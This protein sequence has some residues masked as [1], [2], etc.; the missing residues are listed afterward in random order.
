M[1]RSFSYLASFSFFTVLFVEDQADNSTL[2]VSSN[3]TLFEAEEGAKHKAFLL[4]M[5]KRLMKKLIRYFGVKN[6]E[7]IQKEKHMLILATAVHG[8]LEQQQCQQGMGMWK[9]GR[10]YHYGRRRNH[11]N[12]I[13]FIGTRLTSDIFYEF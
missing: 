8:E 7:E 5:S 11:R 9:G 4:R 10:L 1:N 13:F 2:E 3:T 12:R 6:D